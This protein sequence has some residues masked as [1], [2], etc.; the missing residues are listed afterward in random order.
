MN[1]GEF[2][3]FYYKFIHDVYL[4]QKRDGTLPPNALDVNDP[5]SL[6]SQSI[7]AVI[8]A[9]G[10]T[11]AKQI[12]AN[13]GVTPLPVYSAPAAKPAAPKP[14]EVGSI[15]GGYRLKGGD[16]RQQE[17]GCGCPQ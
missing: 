16:P 9:R 17:T 10:Q 2:A 12:A 13:G 6:I 3:G 14:P 11:L 15:H 1:P 8:N 7:S 5:Q 4:P